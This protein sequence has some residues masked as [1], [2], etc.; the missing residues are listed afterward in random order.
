MK[1]F[2]CAV[3]IL[4]SLFS[5]GCASKYME[6]VIH[7][8]ATGQLAPDQS[9][10][11]FFRDTG[12]GGAIQAPVAEGIDGDVVFVGI[13]SANTKFLHKTTPGE[14]IYVVGGESSNVLFA[15]LEP[16]KFY[17]V[18]VSP[19]M[20]IFKA[21]FEFE[22]VSPLQE[23]NLQ[24]LSDG[25]AGCKWVAPNPLSQAWF[26][27]N[28]SNLREKLENALKKDKDREPADRAV[29]NPENGIAELLQ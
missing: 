17:Y 8:A 23:K 16:Q 1:R 24:D 25:L 18:R 13:I 11:V 29:V 5:A 14:H 15:N 12:F 9:A 22:P 2:V 4:S 3:F 19:K 6:P 21:R 7:D 20:G 10:I 26:A 27:E 28:K